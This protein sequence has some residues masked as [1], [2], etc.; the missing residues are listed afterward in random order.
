MTGRWSP[1]RPA[2]T[3]ARAGGPPVE[4]ARPTTPSVLKQAGYRTGLVGKW[5][6]GLG[7]HDL[8]FNKEIKPGPVELGFDYAFFFPATGDRVPC[9]FIENHRVVGLDAN[10]PIRTSY[11]HKIGDEPTGKEHPELLKMKPSH[12]HDN[13]IINGIS[14]IGW[15]GGGKSA[16]WVDELMADTLT[17]KSSQ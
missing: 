10:D 6:I 8:D 3:R 17:T 12:G 11:T 2:R 5:H 1:P 14:R 9:V 15:M 16:R 7:R 13:T 4:A